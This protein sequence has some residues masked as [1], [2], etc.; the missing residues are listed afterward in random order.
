MLSS[1]CYYYYYLKKD[2]TCR[3]LKAATTRLQLTMNGDRK[4]TLSLRRCVGTRIS[5]TLLVWQMSDG[6][7]DVIGGER[8]QQR[9]R[10]RGGV[11]RWCSVSCWG[12]DASNFVVENWRSLWA[13]Y[14]V[15]DIVSVALPTVPWHRRKHRALNAARDNHPPVS[16][17]LH[18]PLDSGEDVGPFMMLPGLSSSSTQLLLWWLCF[19]MLCSEYASCKLVKWEVVNGW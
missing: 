17:F 9:A 3:K 7:N 8:R 16:S 12:A 13:S 2:L 19:I 6:S 5:G 14:H 15:S 10:R 4:S 11:G 18:L 1:C